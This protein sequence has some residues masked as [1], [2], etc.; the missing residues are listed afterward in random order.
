T[1]EAHGF[2][3]GFD[4]NLPM[5]AGEIQ[6]PALGKDIQCYD[7]EGRSIIGKLGELVLT[8]RSPSFPL[9]LW[10]DEDGSVLHENYLSL[11]PGSWCPHDECWINPKSRG[12]VI[13]GRSDD[14]LV[15]NGE[16]FGS[17][18]V[19]FAK[20]LF[21]VHDLEEVH[22]YIC[23]GQTSPDGDVR[24]VL[25]VK[26][27]EG[28]RFT[29]QLSERISQKI[30]EVLWREL[31]PEVILDVKDIPYNINGKR[32]ESTVKKIIHTNIV[33]EVNNIRNPE[34]LSYFCNRPE[35]VSYVQSS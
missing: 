11:Y 30:E 23:V 5:L 1:T 25:F 19:Y 16:L 34:C 6:A 3:S 4:L 21:V 29:P 28:L 8:V 7:K 24:C 13:I 35:V 32:M 33:P 9:Y 20:M 2:L 15:Q 22:D 14:I 12:I 27:R 18:D 31:V 26:L 10:K 17:A